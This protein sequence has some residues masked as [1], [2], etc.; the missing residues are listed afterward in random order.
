ML[1]R[2]EVQQA[3]TVRVPKYDTFFSMLEKK[4][5]TRGVAILP[6]PLQTPLSG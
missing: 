1:E 6:E 2:V 5:K 4:Q 3:P